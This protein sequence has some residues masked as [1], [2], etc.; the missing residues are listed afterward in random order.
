MTSI[1]FLVPKLDP[2]TY[3]VTVV[4]KIGTSALLAGGFEV[5]GV[6]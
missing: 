1:H 4:N 2:G 3:D 6:P 5:L